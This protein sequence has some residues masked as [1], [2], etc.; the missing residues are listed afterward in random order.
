MTHN[1][2][3]GRAGAAGVPGGAAAG[4]AAVRGGGYGRRGTGQRA[5]EAGGGPRCPSG[6]GLAV[7]GQGIVAQ[8]FGRGHDAGQ[9]GEIAIEPSA[10]A[11]P[12]LGVVGQPG[13][14][15]LF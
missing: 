12:C 3:R 13:L 6:P 11:A 9:G 7:V 10:L 15:V 1:T 8:L 14:G 4:G 2:A 5:L